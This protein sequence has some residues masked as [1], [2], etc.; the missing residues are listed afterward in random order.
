M[1]HD[2]DDDDDDDDDGTRTKIEA[3][4]RIHGVCGRSLRP[5]VFLGISPTDIRNV[6]VNTIEIYD[7]Y[8]VYMCK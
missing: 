4:G 2:F 8:G 1:I 5:A 6:Y 7:F 3:T